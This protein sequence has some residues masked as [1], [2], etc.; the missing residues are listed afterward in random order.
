MYAGM[1]DISASYGYSAYLAAVR[2]LW[3]NTIGKK[4]YVTGGLG[5]R[6]DGEEFGDN[7]EL[8]NLTAYSETC[9][10]IGGVYWAERMFRLTGKANY[11]DVLER[12][13]Y[14][15]VIAGIS[16]AGTEFFYP[17]ALESNGEYKFNKGA[18][19]RQA[20]FDCSC[21][22]TNLIRFIPYIPNLIYATQGNTAYINLFMSNKANISLEKGNVALEQQTGYP[23]NGNVKI[24][25]KPEKPQPFT[26]KIRIPSWVQNVPAPGSLYHYT[27]KP[28]ESYHVSV[29]GKL[30]AQKTDKDGYLEI[31]RTWQAGDEIELQLPMQARTVEADA[32]VKDNVGKYAVERGPLV[33]CMEEIDN[34]STFAKTVS[35]SSFTT[36]WDSSLLS[37]VNVI[38]EKSD[39]N[40]FMLIPYYTWS[41][42]GVGKMKVWK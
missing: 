29:N 10:A 22:P 32:N 41:N 7:Y 9:A 8:P 13:L 40:E 17:N 39:D 16:L 26:L 1:T 19:T 25:V 20:W 27:D 36:E 31:T 35:P 33:Y 5:A 24:A 12:M 14:N 34:P 21:C 6:H 37:G 11:I 3:D 30:Q 18:C 2:I 15:N 23:W 28:A 4:M 38:R 42:R